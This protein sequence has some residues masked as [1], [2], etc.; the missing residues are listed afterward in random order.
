MV[1]AADYV[2]VLLLSILGI[3]LITTLVAMAQMG[4]NA[5]WEKVRSRDN[6]TDAR[7]GIGEVVFVV[8]GILAW[9]GT[10]TP[11]SYLE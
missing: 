3:V 6:L 5:Y 8:I 11:P 7:V 9:L 10:I 1:L 2:V 4:L